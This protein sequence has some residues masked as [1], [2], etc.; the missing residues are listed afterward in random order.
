M[1]ASRTSQFALLLP[2]VVAAVALTACGR[3]DDGRT[4]GHRF[5]A[6]GYASRPGIGRPVFRPVKAGACCPRSSGT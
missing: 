6:G 3:E 4:A 1:K 5:C 2:A